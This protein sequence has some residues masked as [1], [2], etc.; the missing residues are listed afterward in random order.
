LAKCIKTG[1][2]PSRSGTDDDLFR[3]KKQVF[4][5]PESMRRQCGLAR[6]FTG[7]AV[8]HLAEMNR[9]IDSDQHEAKQK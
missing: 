1:T 8:F 3:Q 7:V 5:R 2:V 4:M 9:H 6:L